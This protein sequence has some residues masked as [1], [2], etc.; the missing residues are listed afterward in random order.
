MR[1]HVMHSLMSQR[2]RAGVV[3]LQDDMLCMIKRVRRGSTYYLF[4][5]GGVEIGESP[6]EA[7]KREAWEELGLRVRPGRLIGDFAHNNE[8]HLFY[9]AEV[10]GG[11]FGTGTGEEYV[12]EFHE[13]VGTY[14]PVW[15]SVAE[16]CSLD[17][18]PMELCRALL[19]EGP[20]MQ[21][22]VLSPQP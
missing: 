2:V 6:M 14:K 7:A 13:S 20:G 16:A 9:L 15:L 1:P 3:L 8:R 18:R 10:T 5:G 12:S 19:H 22:L 11:Q 4:P 17:S 21:T